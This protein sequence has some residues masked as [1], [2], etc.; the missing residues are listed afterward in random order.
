MTARA[1]Q[2]L[3]P[4][5]ELVAMLSTAIES[6]VADL[7]PDGRRE[8]AEWVAP[9]RWGG[10]GRSLSVHLVGG[11]AGVWRDFATGDKGG[12]ALDLV[13]DL[14]CDGNKSQAVQWA[15]GWLGLDQV[16]PQTL[17]RKRRAAQVSA[18]QRKEQSA[19]DQEKRKQVARAI[20]LGAQPIDGSPVAAY[21]R[22]RGIDLNCLPGMPR[23]LRYA[24]KCWNAE[25][26]RELPA[27]VA[28]INDD[29]GQHVATHRTWIDQ[30]ERNP[31]RWRKAN[32][33]NAKSTIGTFAGGW[34]KLSRSVSRRPWKDVQGTDVIAV[35]EGIENAL[36]VAQL[37]PE[38]RVIAAVS[39]ANMGGLR[40]PKS[41]R[42][43]VICADND[44]PGHPAR[45]AL[46]KAVAHLMADGIIVRLAHPDPKFKDWNDQLQAELGYE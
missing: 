32:L 33:K 15:R 30:D 2:T 43:I 21:L 29:A 25:T 5:A 10:S 14:V 1:R 7:L 12:D 36:S 35:A 18:G 8:G 41:V 16:D 17:Q 3:M 22:G 24:P 19:A 23:A 31:D 13:A 45:K 4:I 39:L 26:D 20:W 9:S 44:P 6:L 28:A 38:W 11:K 46:E 42:E 37:V 34:I 40:M 27:M